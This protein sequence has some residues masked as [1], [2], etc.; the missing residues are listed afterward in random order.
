MV[1]RTLPGIGLKGFWGDGA[2]GWGDDN[3]QNLLLLSTLVQPIAAS[4]TATLPTTPVNGYITIVPSG[5]NINKVAVRDNNA[6]VY[7]TP[8]EGF[9]VYVL[10][11]D[12]TATF[13]GTT[14]DL[15]WVVTADT[16]LAKGAFQTFMRATIQTAEVTLN[17]GKVV[18]PNITAPQGSLIM[19]VAVDVIT[20]IAGTASLN[21]DFGT[22]G[23]WGNGFTASVPIDKAAG[24]QRFVSPYAVLPVQ[25]GAVR[26]NLCVADNSADAFTA[27]K[28]RVAVYM[29]TVG[30]PDPVAA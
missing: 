9:E 27:G 30:L 28:V 26:L 20:A 13:N 21:V 1:A 10:D 22:A 14:W 7:I 6:W 4:L 18:S 16:L 3:D 29:L 17:T 12:R 2:S 25:F 19:G 11:A 8:T 15:A 23:T 24:T 5:A